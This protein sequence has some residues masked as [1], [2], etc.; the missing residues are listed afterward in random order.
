MKKIYLAITLLAMFCDL[1]GC[2]N[3]GHIGH[4]FGT[5]ALVDFMKEDMGLDSGSGI[6][7]SPAGIFDESEIEKTTFNFQ[8][9]IVK[10]IY[11]EGHH[12]WTQRVA[13]WYE[14]ESGKGDVLVLK[15][16]NHDY[17]NNP[18]E[19][20]YS[21]PEWLG[22]NNCMEV[23]LYFRKNTSREIVLE[24]EPDYGVKYVYTLRKTW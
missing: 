20:N 11:D 4:L 9:D 6:V 2:Q 23:R 19:G 17:N 21:S 18:G 5:W 22:W 13:T 10:I 24:W 3:D 14:A 16:D 1:S 12:D 7:D 15:F 8:N